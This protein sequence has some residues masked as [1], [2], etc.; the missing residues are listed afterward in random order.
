[1][2]FCRATPA[3]MMTSRSAQRAIPRLQSSGT[4]HT[5]CQRMINRQHLSRMSTISQL[6]FATDDKKRLTAIEGS[7]QPLL[8]AAGGNWSVTAD[9]KGIHRQVRFKTFRQASNFM[10]EMIPK[11]AE[12]RHHPTWSNTYNLVELTWS[13]H[14]DK[15]SKMAGLSELDVQMAKTSDELAAKCGEQQVSF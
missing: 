12:T 8:Q 4:P 2:A 1:M 13:T 9:S 15:E 3:M 11:I 7:I 6:T 5:T 14:R 10:I